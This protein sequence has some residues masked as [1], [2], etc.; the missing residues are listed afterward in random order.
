MGRFDDVR[1]G[2][3]FDC[4]LTEYLGPKK[5]PTNH[6]PLSRYQGPFA[7]HLIILQPIYERVPAGRLA[8]AVQ[9][10]KA[11]QGFPSQA[12]WLPQ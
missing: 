12:C 2:R 3:I 8:H 1:L 5:V 11:C 9:C 6:S 10:A 7:Y 4:A